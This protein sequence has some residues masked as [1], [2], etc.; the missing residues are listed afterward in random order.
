MVTRHLLDSAQL[1]A[2]EGHGG[3]VTLIQRSG[4]ATK[5]N[6]HL[7]CLVLDGV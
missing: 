5:L 7:H 2:E 4:S 3:A 1:A 6:L